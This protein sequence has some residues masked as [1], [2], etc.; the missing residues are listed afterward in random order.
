M[1]VLDYNL[2]DRPASRVEVVKSVVANFIE[3]RP[4]DRIGIVVFAGA[5]SLVSPLTLDHDWLKQN[6][7]RVRTGLIEDSTASGSALTTCVN[8]LRDQPSKSKGIVLLTDGMS[9]AGAVAPQTAAE[10]AR[11]MAVKVYTVAA[12]SKAQAAVPMKDRSEERGVGKE[13]RSRWSPY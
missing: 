10:T 4:N 11:A 5:P 13:C 7:E 1:K 8:R 2:G 3:A 12:G 6:L 9:N